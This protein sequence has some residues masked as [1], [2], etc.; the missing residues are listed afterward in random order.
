[1]RLLVECRTI[2][3]GTSGGIENFVY[4]LVRGLLELDTEDEIRLDVPPGTTAAWEA[5]LPSS[6]RLRFAEDPFVARYRRWSRAVPPLRW[7]VGV[8]RRVRPSATRPLEG[9]RR[10]WVAE[11]S[12]WADVVYYPF[13]RDALVHHGVPTVLTMHDFFDFDM[14]GDG[15]WAAVERANLSRVDRIVT[16]WPF[17]QRR[18]AELFPER[19]ASAA[20]I[21]FLFDRPAPTAGRAGAPERLLLYP[22]ATA[23]HKNHEALLRALGLLRAR[24]EESVRLVCTGP[25]DA[26][27][28]QRLSD[29]ATSMGVGGDVEFRGFVSREEVHGLYARAAAVVAPTLYE[30][31]SGAVLEAFQRGLPV[32]CSRIPALEETIAF[33]DGSARFFDPHQPASIADAIRDILAQPEEYMEGSRRAGRALSGLAPHVTAARYREVFAWAAGGPPPA[34][35]PRA[36]LEP[37]CVE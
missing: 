30:A 13:Q 28:V 21:P 12:A 8:A 25:M 29:L 34:W 18:L 1:M 33:L 7:A 14:A 10:K 15:R 26:A 36:P 16:S 2:V 5:R 4:A 19:A 22:A 35:L 6:P 37:R 31:F 23:P 27:A 11:A 24:G 9:P 3:P 20:M 32:A 17:P